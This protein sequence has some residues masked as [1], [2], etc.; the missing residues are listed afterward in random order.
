MG[1]MKSKLT[2]N[3]NRPIFEKFAKFKTVKNNLIY[4]IRKIREIQVPR[5]IQK[6][7]ILEN[8]I[9]QKLSHLRYLNQRSDNRFFFRFRGLDDKGKYVLIMTVSQNVSYV[10]L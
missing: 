5:K 6:S 4:V 9:L 3:N 7:V 8:S 10:L 1:M 2:K